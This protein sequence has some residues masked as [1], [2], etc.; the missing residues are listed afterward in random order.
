MSTVYIMDHIWVRNCMDEFLFV[1][2]RLK[3]THEGQTLV[4]T[5]YFFRQWG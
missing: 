4:N 1:D 5:L 3:P 2:F